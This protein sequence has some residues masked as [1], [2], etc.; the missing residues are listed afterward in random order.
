MQTKIHAI[1]SLWYLDVIRSP[2]STAA[3]LLRSSSTCQSLSCESEVGVHEGDI[4][5]RNIG[6]PTLEDTT[7]GLDWG[8]QLPVMREVERYN[9]HSQHS[10]RGSGMEQGSG[11]G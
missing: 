1:C 10:R 9:Q 4:R 5:P 2:K 8:C 7:P 6:V 11:T 3:L